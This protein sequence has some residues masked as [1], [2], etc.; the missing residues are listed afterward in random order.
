M[1]VKGLFRDASCSVQSLERLG[2]GAKCFVA[3]G[4]EG[5]EMLSIS[6]IVGNRFLSDGRCFVSGGVSL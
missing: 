3:F 2:D 5:P 1:G 6:A 4:A